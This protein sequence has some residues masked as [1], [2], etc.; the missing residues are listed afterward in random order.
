MAAMIDLSE[1]R[2]LITE[3]A[4]LVEVLPRAEYD[5]GRLPGAI[6]IPLAELDAQT[7]AVLETGR[8]VVV[9]CWDCF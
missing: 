3:G 5:E 4:Q 2:T 6:S 7:T 1:L 8:A 9:S